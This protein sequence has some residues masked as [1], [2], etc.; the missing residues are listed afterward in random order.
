VTI[1]G[2]EQPPRPFV[3]GADAIGIAEQKASLLV[4]IVTIC[5]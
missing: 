5:R 2:Q 4:A 3:A 1:A